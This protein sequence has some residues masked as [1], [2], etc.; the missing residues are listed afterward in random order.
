[1]ASVLVLYPNKS[2]IQFQLLCQVQPHFL[3]RLLELL[4]LLL[5]HLDSLR[6]IAHRGIFQQGA[7]NH[8]EAERK[9]NIQ[10]LHVGY[11]WQ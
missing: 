9:V 2:L 3:N 8:A 1:M 7:K 10:S 5:V 6:G 4:K 11:L